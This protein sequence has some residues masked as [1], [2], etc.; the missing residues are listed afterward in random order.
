MAR[1]FS[2]LTYVIRALSTFIV[3]VPFLVPAARLALSVPSLIHSIKVT[4]N[5]PENTQNAAESGIV[6]LNHGLVIFSV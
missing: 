4:R 1:S 5:N 6:A 2:S 3:A